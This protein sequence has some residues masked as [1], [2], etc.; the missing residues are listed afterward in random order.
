MSITKDINEI[1]HLEVFLARYKD[2]ALEDMYSQRNKL[3]AEMRDYQQSNELIQYEELENFL[4]RKIE[5]ALLEKTLFLKRR[6]SVFE[7][8]NCGLLCAIEET[9]CRRCGKSLLANR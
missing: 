8:P 9:A 2:M 4:D 7:Y 6:E 1:Y 3:L 5:I